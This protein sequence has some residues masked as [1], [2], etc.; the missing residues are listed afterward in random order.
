MHVR[1]GD[2]GTG[3]K[4]LGFLN[5]KYF[6]LHKIKFPKADKII[7]DELIAGIKEK[8]GPEEFSKTFEEGNSL[9]LD[10]IIELMLS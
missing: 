2:Y 7:F 8:L 4:L 3:A 9:T 10:D 1:D 6:K 5:V